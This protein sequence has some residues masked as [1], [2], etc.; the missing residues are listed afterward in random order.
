MGLTK[1]QAD[2]AKKKFQAK[3]A[4]AENGKVIKK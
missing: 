3:K 1:E 4:K 2:K